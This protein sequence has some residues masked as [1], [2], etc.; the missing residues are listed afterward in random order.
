MAAASF[1]PASSSGG[2]D[3]T[4]NLEVDYGSEENASIVYKTLAVDKELQPDKVKREMTLS[5]SKLAVHFA[6][7]EARFLRASFSAF[8]DL[9][10]LVTKLV[11]EYG[12]AMEEHS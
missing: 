6:A 4:C 12:V 3:F 7:V 9:M 11:E 5:G 1:P 8:V 10:G 2:W